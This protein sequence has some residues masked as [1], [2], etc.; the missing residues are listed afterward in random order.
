MSAFDVEDTSCRLIIQL[1]VHARIDAALL[2]S[3]NVLQV[4]I[5]G[6]MNIMH[7]NSKVFVWLLLMTP[8]FAF[9][10]P[11]VDDRFSISLGAFVTDRSTDTQ[12][13]SDVLGKGTVIDFED[14]LGL[15]SS[16]SVFRID[17]HYRFSQ[18]H[19]VNFSVFDLSR[20]SSATILR[21]I[22]YGD[23]IFPIDTVVNTS[24]D[25]N[26]YKLTYAYSFMQRDS[27]YLGVSLG[28]HIGDSK[29]G[30]DQQSLGQFEVSSI[31]APL[32]VIGLIG[33]YELTDR[34]TLGASGELFAFE[35]DNVDGSLV[36]LYV[37]ID[38]QIIDHIA[39]GLGFNSVHFDVDATKSD[40]SGS[41]DW[42]YE[43][44]LLF[45]KFDF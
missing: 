10:E 41:L 19:R 30:L 17:G 16:D 7:S 32:P 21:D 15:D 20:D 31:T 1:Y 44:A 22:Q 2:L 33:E 24:F 27:G 39:L 5:R 34:L 23:K 11:G 45:F 43:G 4:L 26:I 6:L 3:R 42:R 8:A 12:L 13:D 36:D 25:L 35:F 40:F 29:I 38:Y 14:D 28:I 37:G 9:A 18:K